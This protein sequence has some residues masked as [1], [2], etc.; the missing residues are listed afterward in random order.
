M[1]DRVRKIRTGP[2]P[3]VPD[4]ALAGATWFERRGLPLVLLAG[5]L[6]LFAVQ[7]GLRLF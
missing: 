5:V 7:A 4:G 2:L 6:G 1:A 3:R